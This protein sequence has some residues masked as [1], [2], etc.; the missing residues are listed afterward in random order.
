MGQDLDPRADLYAAAGV[1]YESLTG[2]TPHEADNAM[3]LI[4][5]VLEEV[6]KAPSEWNSE[7]PPAL[8]EL[9]MRALAVDRNQRPVSA[10]ALHDQL[11][12]IG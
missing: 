1:I 10:A 6:P 3:T 12:A 11:A 5:K 8:D 4:A 2:H 7:V 9:V